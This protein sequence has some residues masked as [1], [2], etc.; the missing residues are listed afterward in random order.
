[1]TGTAR[2]GSPAGNRHHLA[3]LFTDLSDSTGIA[4]S[5][6]PEHYAELLQPLRD[7][8]SATIAEHGGEI[9]RIDGDGALCIFG[10]PHSHEDAG[11][12][13]TEAAVDLHRA[14]AAMDR[15]GSPG[16][17][18]IRLHSGIH[19]GV[20]LLRQGDITRG[21]YEP[22]GDATNVAARL[23]DMAEPGEIIVSEAAL[24]ADRHFF[25]TGPRRYLRIA[26]HA[27]DLAVIAVHD[28]ET[29]S[30][31]FDARTRQGMTPF[32]GRIAE[33]ARLHAWLGGPASVRGPALLAGPPGIGKTRLLGEFLTEA[34][35]RGVTVHRGYCEAYLG[36]PPLQP[37]VQLAA[38]IAA[39]HPAAPPAAEIGGGAD[40]DAHL[41]R[42][43]EGMQ[44]LIDH[45]VAEG[46]AIFAIDDWQWADDASR[47]LLDALVSVADGRARFLLVSRETDA[48]LETA[49]PAEIIPVPPLPDIE[50]Q[51][52]VD[53]L[54]PASDPA[55]AERIRAE[56]GGNPLFLE[57]LCHASG[58]RHGAT[59]PSA[60]SSAWLD[61]LI[62]A[63]FADLPPDQ[64]EIVRRASVIGHAVPAGLFTAVT[65]VAPDD[66][67]I[68]SLA[69]ADFLYPGDISGTLRFKH[70]ITR[71]AVYRAIGLER[72]Q[73]LH[74]RVIVA[75]GEESAAPN[76]EALAYHHHAAGRIGAAVPHAIKAGE[77]ALAAGAL[78]RARAHF[79]AAFEG[80]PALP[81]TDPA[82]V[83]AWKL[84]NKYGLACIAD[85]SP[86]QLPVL[87]AMAARLKT[88]GQAEALTRSNYWIGAIAYGLGD[89]RRSAAYL[90]AARETALG[91]GRAR[92][93]AQIETKLAQSLSAAGAY[94]E[95]DA[96]FDRVL[97]VIR[98]H[99]GR[100]DHETLAYALCCHGFLLADQGDFPAAYAR[101]A[102]AEAFL[103]RLSPAPL[104]S[105][106]TQA[107]A[108]C[109]MRGQWARAVEQARLCL[110][111][112]GRT[113]ARYQ[114]MMARALGAFGQWQ[115]DRDSAAVDTLVRAAHWFAADASQQRTSLVYGWL[116]E[117]ME[118][119][120][121]AETA[122][123][124]AARTLLRVHRGGDRLGE[125]MAYRAMARLAASGGSRC[126]P[127]RY[128]A[129]AYRSAELRRSPRERAQT[130]LCEAGLALAQDDRSRALPLLRQ[131]SAT[132]EA[133]GM[134]PFLKQ[135]RALAS[136]NR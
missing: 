8:L 14:V 119:T 97:P 7:L 108:V 6:E 94:P 90:A 2:P 31:R 57:E 118:Q 32:T 19:A 83:E 4:T 30:T 39:T 35:A 25:R 34:A 26:G 107:A 84:V 128:L 88:A 134:Q 96:M 126:A 92:L 123:H 28:R 116:A 23:S 121:Q 15:A 112:C 47:K 109:L 87:N 17:A 67:V 5:M 70:G 74:L 104:A 136:A 3:I 113:H 49:L 91:L 38:S 54:L 48:R 98:H 37:F 110:D 114:A 1:M 99:D 69:Q 33:R 135:A 133:L 10:Y 130:E 55:Q 50:V 63:R 103:G 78:D 93:V 52:A 68:A 65:G 89:G 106:Y 18:P 132:F 115:I 72:R 40:A 100:N 76:P 46:P 58:R 12:R 43:T 117:I 102:E 11:R 79:R 105:Y 16:G 81:A 125:A 24:G 59:A 41:Q 45:A 111:A 95:A 64:A 62:Q 42:F 71:D 22:L 53:A 120:G 27:A 20:V 29:V 101:Y 85:P 124:Y 13:A 36:A 56:S 75:L 77:A 122:R 21:R 66:P 129:A 131:A 51:M 73:E 9:V 80:L 82:V 60:G 127:D 61:M 86:E 44:R